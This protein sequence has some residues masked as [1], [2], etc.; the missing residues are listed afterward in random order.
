MLINVKMPTIVD[1][2]ERDKFCAQLSMKTFYNLDFGV[3]ILVINLFY[4]GG[5]IASR[6]GSVPVFL[7]KRMAICGG[8]DLTP[9]P[10]AH[11]LY[12]HLWQC[13]LWDVV[14]VCFA[15][16]KLVFVLAWFL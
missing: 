9:L 10:T 4:R 16:I 15:A 3:F 13:L 2:Y 7:R 14:I 12:F 11:V 5:P 1:I 6:W 8:P